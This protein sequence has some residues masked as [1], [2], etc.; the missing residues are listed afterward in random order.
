MATSLYKLQI[1]K[2]DGFGLYYDSRDGGVDFI[3]K[4]FNN[5]PVPIEVGIGK[6]SKKQITKAIKRYKADYGVVISN[7]TDHIVMD[8]NVIFIP[9]ET[10][11]YL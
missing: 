11:S 10:F 8:E 9:V 2:K 5:K 6:K 1:S 4:S 3:V 7:K